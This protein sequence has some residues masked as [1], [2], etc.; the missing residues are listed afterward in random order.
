MSGRAF[1]VI[2]VAP[3]GTGKTTLAKRLIK[4]VPNLKYSVSA[5][6][7][8]PRKG[9]K[10]GIDYYFLDEAT[11][12]KWI[13]EGKFCE[14]AKVYENYYG[15]PKEPFLRY[16]NEGYKVLMDLD[17]QGAKSIKELHPEGI[18]I[19]ILPPSSKDLKNRLIK[20]E[21]DSQKIKERLKHMDEELSHCK[22][23]DY[24]VIN[25][26]IDETVRKLKAI[27]EAEECKVKNER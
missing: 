12:M 10:N 19:F 4:K 21:K 3:S 6:T 27:I 24:I 23:F 26:T 16:L 11:F 1:P 15:T 7:R 22:E 20:R 9:E 25:K 14:W 5:T 8:A 13:K 2:L 18:A 17:I